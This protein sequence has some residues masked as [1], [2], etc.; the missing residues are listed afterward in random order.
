MNFT[1]GEYKKLLGY[2]K[3]HYKFIPH[4]EKIEKICFISNQTT[5][6]FGE[7]KETEKQAFYFQIIRT[8]KKSID[9]I[10]EPLYEGWV[11]RDQLEKGESRFYRHAKWTDTITNVII[12]S[13]K[14]TLNAYQGKYITFPY[15]WDYHN[16]RISPN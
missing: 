9:A 10:I 2:I 11:Y 3:V 12:M 7:I 16:I 4:G 8:K 14:G 15:C 13:N 1:M 5:D 6:K